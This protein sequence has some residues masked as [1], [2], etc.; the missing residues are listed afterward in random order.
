MVLLGLTGR[1]IWE[2]THKTRAKL[3]RGITTTKRRIS[4]ALGLDEEPTD[5]VDRALAGLP[6][7]PQVR[8]KSRREML[9]SVASE[10]HDD[11]APPGSADANGGAAAPQQPLPVVARPP[12]VLRGEARLAKLREERMLMFIAAV[13]ESFGKIFLAENGGDQTERRL[14]ST[15][16]GGGAAAAASASPARPPL[17]SNAAA[18]PPRAGSGGDLRGI[19][20]HRAGR[21]S[22]GQR[23]A[24][25]GATPLPRASSATP[26]GSALQGWPG[27][28]P[29][30][31]SATTQRTRGDHRRSD[32]DR[33]R[34]QPR[35]SVEGSS[36]R[37]KRPTSRAEE[38]S[39]PVGPSRPA[40]AAVG[41]SGARRTSSQSQARP[42]LAAQESD[43]RSYDSQLQKAGVGAA[44]N[45]E[46]RS[47]T[48]M[49]PPAPVAP[50]QP[51]TRW[52]ARGKS[53]G[54]LRTTAPAEEQDDLLQG[55]WGVGVGR[56]KSDGGGRL[57]A[58][59][60]AA[61]NAPV[62]PEEEGWRIDDG[63]G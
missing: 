59:V 34:Q 1:I 43:W 31:F 10:S 47:A 13:E 20:V 11:D 2:D 41:A 39:P 46:R 38:S 14:E 51:P 9:H 15:P 42:P 37:P 55:R 50:P 30:S 17:G 36:G 27:V 19:V 35:A 26:S 7:R 58:W 40:G 48:A 29:Q 12:A 16:A 21:H 3:A 18:T 44:S 28:S 22:S 52:L 5:P 6:L 56:T 25:G 32:E 54:H 23:E 53:F 49:D 57:A 4:T 24:G 45:G 61:G 60:A 33:S 62:P 63:A 8:R